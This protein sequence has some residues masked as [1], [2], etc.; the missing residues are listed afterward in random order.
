MSIDEIHRDHDHE[1]DLMVERLEDQFDTV[2]AQ[3]V[4]DIVHECA[5]RF[6][7]APVQS[8]VCVLTEKRAR[9]LLRA[10]SAA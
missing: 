5:A 9:A 8:F 6:D 7:H 1:L 10:S 4:N 3:T 2:A